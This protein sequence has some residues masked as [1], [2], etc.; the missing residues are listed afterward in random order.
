MVDFN[1]SEIKEKVTTENI[2]ELLQEWG[3]DPEYTPFG[4]ISATI[5]HNKPGE[6]S[7]KLYYYENSNLFQCYTGC[8]GYF[9][10]FELVIKVA[11][12]QQRKIIDLNEAIHWIANRFGFSGISHKDLFNGTGAQDW[13]VFANYERI[14]E[15]VP[16]AKQEIK[17]KEYD[18]SILSR[19]NY[20]IKNKPWL[21]E[22]IG[23]EALNQAQIGFYPGGDQITI[24]H[25]DPGNRFIGLRGRTLCSDEAERFGKYRPIRVNQQTYNHPLGMNLYNLNFSK[26]NIKTMKK[27]ILFEAE[28]S[29]LMYKTYFGLENDISVA[30]CSS[31]VSAY[32]IQM[33]REAGAEEIVIA[34]DRQFQEIGDEEFKH[35]VK[36]LTA[37]NNR[38]KNEVLITLMF[39][40]MMI[41]RY[42]ASPIDDG[43]EKFLRLFK[44]RILL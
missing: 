20:Q 41:T 6:G 44:E 7:R 25:F 1:K 29:T 18:K 31:N 12:I 19:F 2:F 42:K 43:P 38:Y 15:L 5:C 3:G 23:Q 40:K 36:G 9:D 35:L 30:C 39:D 17:L 26:Y 34:F 33:L 37:I 21:K 11:E 22:G 14:R 16:K 8:Q 10:I 27:A 28:K 24:P 4:I 32:Q 13:V